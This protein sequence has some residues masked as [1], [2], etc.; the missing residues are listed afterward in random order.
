MTPLEEAVDRILGR[1]PSNLEWQAEGVVAVPI[2]EL[3]ALQKARESEQRVRVYGGHIATDPQGRLRQIQ[4]RM[5]G[6]TEA[7]ITEALE[8][9]LWLRL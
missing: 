1:L 4:E 9:K 7:E 2:S 6:V 8:I 3:V 5:T